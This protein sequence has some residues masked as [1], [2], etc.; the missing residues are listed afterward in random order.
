MYTDKMSAKITHLNWHK[1]SEFKML[2][3]KAS[4]QRASMM[5][6]A[7][8]LAFLDK[9]SKRR[10]MSLICLLLAAT[11]PSITNVDVSMDTFDWKWQL[12]TW[13]LWN[14]TQ[15]YSET[16]NVRWDEEYA[17]RKKCFCPVCPRTERDS[18]SAVEVHGSDRSVLVYN[19][20]MKII[21]ITCTDRV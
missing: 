6:W 7:F 1:S 2:P 11:R 9:Y 16:K 8:S 19:V 13:D 4:A 3:C 18:F 17:W 15:M 12:N 21:I 5:K 20:W 10:A 14:F